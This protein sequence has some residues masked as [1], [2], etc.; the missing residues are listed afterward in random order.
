MSVTDKLQIIIDEYDESFKP[1]ELYTDPVNKFRTSSPQALI[2]TDFEYSTQATKWETLSMTNNRPHTYANT[3]ANNI[4][5][6]QGIGNAGP[7]NVANI[8]VTSN[9]NHVTVFTS[10]TVIV[11]S[12][13]YVTDTAWGP[14]EGTFLVD[15]VQTNSWIRYTAKQRYQNPLLPGVT[16]YNINVP[17]VSAVSNASLFSRANIGIANINFTGQG[18][19]TTQTTA[20]YDIEKNND[21]LV[22][23]YSA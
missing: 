1:S 7:L 2:D 9:S 21:L 13:I 15:A 8:V 10:N 23:Y 11:N 14:A 17:G 16:N 19:N 6:Q 18:Y 20:A 12:M 22:T 3:S 5:I 4:L